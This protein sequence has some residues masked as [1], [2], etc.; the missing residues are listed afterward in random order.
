MTQQS[1]LDPLEAPWH[2]ECFFNG[3]LPLRKLQWSPRGY[4]RVLSFPCSTF[5]ESTAQN[6]KS[7]TLVLGNALQNEKTKLARPARQS[8]EK[9]QIT[10]S[11]ILRATSVTIFLSTVTREKNMK[12]ENNART[13]AATVQTSSTNNSTPIT[14]FYMQLRYSIS[15]VPDTKLP[16][17]HAVS[18][19]VM[20]NLVIY[21]SFSHLPH[22]S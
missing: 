11:T 16:A 14:P 5:S 2:S 18:S 4:R 3:E 20:L 12:T 17:M 13:Q 1:E 8:I 10:I 15:P 19:L 6:T 7:Q 9:N 22:F 21:S